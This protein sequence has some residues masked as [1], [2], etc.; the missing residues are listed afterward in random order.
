MFTDRETCGN[1]G[2]F[3]PRV[4][5]VTHGLTIDLITNGNT[6]NVTG[7]YKGGEKIIIRTKED[8]SFYSK[9]VK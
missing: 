3:I 4:P 1:C 6:S 5:N 2:K 8:S 7:I 9:L